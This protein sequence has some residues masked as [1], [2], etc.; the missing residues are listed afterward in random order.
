[1]FLG[2]SS[3]GLIFYIFTENTFLVNSFVRRILFIPPMIDNH[4]YVL[5]NEN[6][7]FWSHNAIGNM[8]FKYPFDSPINMYIG[9]SV[10]GKEGMSANVGLVTE[11]FFSFHYIGVILHS[12]FIAVF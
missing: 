5:F 7:L 11:G 12:I 6:P 8:L 10:L 4:Y 2:L 1:L 9:E 3:M